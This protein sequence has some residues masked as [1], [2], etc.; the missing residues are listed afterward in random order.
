MSRRTLVVLAVSL[1]VPLAA[2]PA[3]AQV[4]QTVSFN[5]G[6]FAAPAADARPAGDVLVQNLNFLLFNLSDFSGASVG[7]DYLVSFGQY[8]EAGVG[9]GYHNRTVPS[10]YAD[11]THADGSEIV[12]ELKLRVTPVTFTA[13]FLPLGQ[14]RAIQPYVGAGIGLFSWRYAETGEWVDYTDNSIFQASYVD[15]GTK[16]GPVYLGGVRVAGDKFSA[17]VELQYHNATATLDPAVGFL[18]DTVE[19]GGWLT[20]FTFGVKF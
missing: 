18:G 14:R 4:R 5:L 19:L 8:V 7:G 2:A 20:Q 17:G 3:R 16:S 13:R 1:A 11:R 9:I 6:Y 10:L 12:Q 15:S